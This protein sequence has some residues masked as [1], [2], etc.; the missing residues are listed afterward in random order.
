ML[1]VQNRTR[2]RLPRP[3]LF[4]IFHLLTKK[5][6]LDVSLAFIGE[7]AMRTLNRR[8]RKRDTVANVLTFPLTKT[9]GEI[10]INP[11]AARRDAVRFGLS[12]RSMIEKLF[13]H[14]LLHLAG[15]THTNARAA[16]RME[17]RER[18]ILAWLNTR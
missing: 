18:A 2:V 14:G 9:A 10:L 6:T 4:P 3:R 13:L 17:R 8:W 11:H 16:K 5:H 12:F 1:E 7:Q 15:Y